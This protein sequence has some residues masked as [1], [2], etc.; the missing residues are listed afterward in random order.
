MP[1]QNRVNPF[2]QIIESAG[3]GTIMGNRGV[4]HRDKKIVR[5]FKTKHWITCSIHY[6]NAR[7]TMMT[8]NRWTELFFLD[9]ATAFSAGHRPCAYCRN[10]DF[11]LFKKLWIEANADS[12]NLTDFAISKIDDIL[13]QERMSEKGEKRT[14][15]SALKHL[16]DA[17]MVQTDDSDQCYLY[18]NHFLLK[19]SEHG[20]TEMMKA[21]G[22]KVVTVLTPKSMVNVFKLGYSCD[23]H[24]GAKLLLANGNEQ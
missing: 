19:W 9:E 24:P 4:I 12:Y 14:Y 13:H 5:N 7:R 18:C 17:V 21:D 11:K 8:N 22:N 16:P 10:K 15:K 1:L 2:G 6:K 20:Y 3:R 23:I